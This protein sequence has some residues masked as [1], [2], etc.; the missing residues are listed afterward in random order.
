MSCGYWSYTY[1]TWDN[2]CHVGI[3]HIPTLRG[4]CH[5][6]IGH[7]PTLREITYVMWALVIY[8]RYVR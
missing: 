7:I 6:G 8:L 5:V 4:L 3:G 2:L 1:A